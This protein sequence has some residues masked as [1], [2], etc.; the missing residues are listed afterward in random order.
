MGEN[1]FHGVYVKRW[2]IRTDPILL[3][4]ASSVRGYGTSN[5][6]FLQKCIYHENIFW[7]A[8]PKQA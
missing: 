6:C 7:I 3:K 5:M 4:E 2:Y 1:P 8:N